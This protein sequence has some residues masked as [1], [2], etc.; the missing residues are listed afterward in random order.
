M[1]PRACTSEKDLE[2]KVARALTASGVLTFHV[3]PSTYPGLPDRY[4]AG[5]NW[6]EFKYAKTWARVNKDLNRQR[7]WLNKLYA[8]GEGV[9]VCAYVPGRIFFG[10][11]G[12][13]LNFLDDS[14]ALYSSFTRDCQSSADIV[15]AISDS[16]KIPTG[17]II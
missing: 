5:G 15:R 3:D 11:W 14:L 17:D 16:L 13:W 2:D 12:Q 9:F 10:T 7:T 6:I 8:A 1:R 4:V